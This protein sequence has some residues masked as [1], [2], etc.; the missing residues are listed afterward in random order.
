MGMPQINTSTTVGGCTFDTD[1]PM[2]YAC[3]RI[4]ALHGACVR[5]SH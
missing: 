4:D 5:R 2:F 1:C 3:A